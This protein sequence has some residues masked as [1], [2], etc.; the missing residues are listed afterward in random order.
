MTINPTTDEARQLA[1]T[2][3]TGARTAALAVTH[4]ATGAPYVARVAVV[5]DGAAVL[6]LI[7]TLSTHT[8]GLLKD[9]RCALLLG[10]PGSKGDPLTHPRM[11][12]SGTAAQVDKPAHKAAWLAA[13][14]KAQ[15]YY[16]FADFGMYRLS[17]DAIDLNGGFGKAFRLGPDDL[18]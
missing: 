16:D 5:A 4:P 15:L 13:I 14:P 1:R 7:S 12:I 9:P 2:L 10:E 11:T 8:Q 3:L 6:M 18:S 17:P